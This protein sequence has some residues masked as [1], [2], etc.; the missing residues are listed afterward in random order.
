VD[1]RSSLSVARFVE[2]CIAAT[3]ICLQSK[4]I[5]HVHCPAAGNSRIYERIEPLPSWSFD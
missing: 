3:C 5:E 4:G 1:E 2:V